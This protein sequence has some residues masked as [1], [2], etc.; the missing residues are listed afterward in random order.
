[1]CSL[2]LL[3]TPPR[4][5][6]DRLYAQ[7]STLQSAAHV[8]MAAAQAL[9]V[10]GDKDGS[11]AKRAAAERARADAQAALQ[12]AERLTWSANNNERKT[13]QVSGR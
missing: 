6:A 9:L 13:W 5:K 7:H 2:P 8:Y 10:R 11:R 12:E 1:M 4:E 3:Y